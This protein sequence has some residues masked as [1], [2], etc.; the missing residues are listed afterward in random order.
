MCRTASREDRWLCLRG[1]RYRRRAR[2]PAT[3][4]T[5]SSGLVAERTPLILGKNEIVSP[6]A[7][8]AQFPIQLKP[9]SDLSDL[10]NSDRHGT[11]PESVKA[12]CSVLRHS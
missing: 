10:T 3:L 7:E 4:A 12:R 11:L 6:S 8:W 5:A 2:D 9:A 1:T